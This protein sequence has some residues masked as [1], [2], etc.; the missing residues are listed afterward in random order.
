MTSP[1]S[2]A[3]AH[4]PDRMEAIRSSVRDIGR[5]LG[6]RYWLNLTRE[7]RPPTEMMKLLADS[8]LLGVGLA[9]EYGGSGGGL[10]DEVALIEALGLEGLKCVRIVTPAF[11]RR[12]VTTW[13]T[14]EQA[15][16][17][18]ERTLTG[19]HVT[20]FA[21]T[22][23]ES[24]SNAFNMRTKAVRSGDGWTLSGEKTFI[25][26][27]G[28]ADQL[29][30]GARTG[31]DDRGRAAISLFI[32]DLPADGISSAPLNVI[33]SAP[34]LQFTMHFDDAVLPADS[35]VGEE[36]R[37]VRS[38]FSALNPERIL[39]A[40]DVLGLGVFAL[41]QAAEYVRVRS[42]FGKP[43]GSYQGVQHLLARA[44]M[45]LHA[46]RMVTYEAAKAYDRG[47]QPGLAANMAKFL[48]SEAAHAAID[49]AV[50]VYGGAGFDYDSNIMW[51]YEPLR[52]KRVAP[53]NNE[54][55]MNY[56][57]ENALDLPRSY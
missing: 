21:L 4:E 57:A 2:H 11:V 14:P 9:E 46:A 17:I 32:T 54:M 18:V 22:E 45:G 15:N 20:A 34:D 49:A 8:G 31:T 48:A 41:R 52:L 50:Q 25:T 33:A 23:A 13:G 44:Y 19:E 24:G 28:V 6:D 3:V 1:N 26:N 36:G 30:V 12:M 55:V 43:T 51:L 27:G 47:E 35:L 10:A 40:A 56:V 7:K 5:Q 38:M 53:L 42:P 39:V 29:L 16:K 37:G